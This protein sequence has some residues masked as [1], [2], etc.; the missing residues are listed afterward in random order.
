MTGTRIAHLGFDMRMKLKAA[1]TLMEQLYFGSQRA[2]CTAAYNKPAP[3]LIKETLEKLAMLPARITELKRSAARSGA[4]TTLI[5]AKAWIPD[6]EPADII[7]G[8]PGVKEDGSDFNNDDL[9]RLIKEMRPIASKLAEDTYLS[10]FQPVYDAEGKRQPAVIHNVEDL[11]PPIRKHTYAPNIDPSSL[12][13]EEAVFQALSGIDWSTVD[14]QHLG[15]DEEVPTPTDPQP[16][17]LP[18]EDS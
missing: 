4:L 17:N 10:H 15:R 12:L 7:K 8:Y 5:R 9:R 1:Y 11:V 13:H 14:F 6:L 18:D 16:A 3:S 2:I